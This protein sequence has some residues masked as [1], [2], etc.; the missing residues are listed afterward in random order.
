MIAT[1]WTM[2]EHKDSEKGGTR[3]IRDNL[4]VKCLS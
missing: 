1:N 4:I 3:G 2:P